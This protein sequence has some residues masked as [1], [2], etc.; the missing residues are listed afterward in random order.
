MPKRAEISLREVMGTGRAIAVLEISKSPDSAPE[1]FRT[2]KRAEISL[3]EVMGTGR[4]IAAL[5]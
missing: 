5:E 3:R 1:N 4:A 2:P